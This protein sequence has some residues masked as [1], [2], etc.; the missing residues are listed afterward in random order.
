MSKPVEPGIHAQPWRADGRAVFPHVACGERLELLGGTNWYEGMKFDGPTRPGEH[1]VVDVNMPA[2]SVWITGRLLAEDGKPWTRDAMLQLGSGSELPGN[3]TGRFCVPVP[4]HGRDNP[5]AFFAAD[6]GAVEAQIVLPVPLV[7]G[8][9]DVGVVVLKPPPLLVSGQVVVRDAED[10][11]AFLKTLRAHIES[12]DPEAFFGRADRLPVEL[13]AEGRFTVHAV[14][15]NVRYGFFV[16]GNVARGGHRKFEPGTTGL[17]L[18]VSPGGSI[19]ASFLVDP[20][21]G[22]M[23]ISFRPADAPP[24]QA[25]STSHVPCG[26]GRAT[27]DVDSL[28]AGSYRVTA[29]KDALV[30]ADFVVAVQAGK[31]ADDPQLRDHDLRHRGQAVR[32]VVTNEVGAALDATHVAWRP[33]GTGDEMWSVL[34]YTH[35]AGQ[36]TTILSGG[37]V[38][39]CVWAAGHRAV[40]QAGVRDSVALVLPPLPQVT[41]RLVDLVELPPGVTAQLQWE[42]LDNGPAPVAWEATGATRAAAIVHEARRG[43]PLPQLL[44]DGAAKCWAVPGERLRARLKLRGPLAHSEPID[45]APAELHA[46]TFAAG[47]VIELRADP[48][49]VHA[50]LRKLAGK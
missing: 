40:D 7:A 3:P 1:L 30:L 43:G 16:D 42:R 41:L 23:T 8:A 50:A 13:D 31:A 47:Q 15:R 26:S 22:Y 12:W 32:V 21:W 2:G 35:A 37:A 38:D 29:I 14:A 28:P 17:V 49:A 34:R 20:A 5:R 10:G 45:L 9:N 44:A 33:V 46:T 24:A 39:V 25:C 18:E 48:E 4:E 27:A 36:G 6:G 19:A 11:A